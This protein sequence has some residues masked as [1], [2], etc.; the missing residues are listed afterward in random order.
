MCEDGGKCVVFLLA[1]PS[2]LSY[3]HFIHSPHHPSSFVNL[4]RTR[5][6]GGTIL[7]L[8]SLGTHLRENGMG[9]LPV[10]GLRQHLRGITPLS[11]TFNLF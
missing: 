6:K 9:I 4:V 2:T 11:T 8:T 7:E 5:R 1:F 3:C 10:V